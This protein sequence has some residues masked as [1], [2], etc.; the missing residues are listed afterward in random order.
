MEDKGN[1]LRD[2]PILLQVTSLMCGW[3]KGMFKNQSHKHKMNSN[4]YFR[5]ILPLFLLN[6]RG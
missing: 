4:K 5:D 1:G 6:F 2:V 3:I